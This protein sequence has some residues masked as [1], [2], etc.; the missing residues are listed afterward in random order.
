M[1]KGH[2]HIAGHGTADLSQFTRLNLHTSGA[3]AWSMAGRVA[4]HSGLQRKAGGWVWS[5]L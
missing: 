4:L 2:G 1:S 3:G 5:Q